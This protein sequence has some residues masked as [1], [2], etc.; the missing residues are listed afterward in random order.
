MKVA[1]FDLDGCLCDDRRRRRLLPRDPLFATDDDYVAY[2]EDLGNDPPMNLDIVDAHIALGHRIAFVTARPQRYYVETIE[3]LENHFDEDLACD[4]ILL[5]RKQGDNSHSPQLKTRLV[6]DCAAFGWANVVAAY[7]DRADVLEA[8][9]RRGVRRL[10]QLTHERDDSPGLSSA[11]TQTQPTTA[12]HTLRQMATTYEERNAVYGD[13]YK[14][15]APVVRAM[16][17]AGV[18][19]DLV[20]SDHWHLFELIVVKLTRFAQSKLQHKDSIHDTGVYAAMIEAELN[21]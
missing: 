2:H 12:A 4:F 9:A 7:D 3:W 1:I 14:H 10:V 21:R 5:M 11:P 15:V 20:T 18:P 13:N 19:S 16:F 6:D 8:Y 17:P